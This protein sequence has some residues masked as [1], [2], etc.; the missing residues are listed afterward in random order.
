MRPQEDVFLNGRHIGWRSFLNFCVTFG[1]FFAQVWQLR[2]CVF[3]I[4]DEME[5]I[6]IYLRLFIV[7][8]LF[9][10]V[11]GHFSEMTLSLRVL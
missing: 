4:S 3:Y 8:T 1:I 10:V 2:I 5:C 6:I 11:P 9:S 7:L